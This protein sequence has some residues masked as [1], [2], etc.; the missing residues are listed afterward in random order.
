MALR[1][2]ACAA[3]P[4]VASF[5]LH[6]FPIET[7]SELKLEW[8]SVLKYTGTT[9]A[10]STDL[11][12]IGNTFSLD[13][14]FQ[15]HY[16]NFGAV[17]GGKAAYKAT[18][19]FK[20]SIDSNETGLRNA[21]AMGQFALGAVP[22][23]VTYGQSAL[24]WGEGVFFRSH[25]I[26]SAV[27]T[28]DA[29]NRGGLTSLKGLAEAG[30]ATVDFTKTKEF[31][32]PVEEATVEFYLP[33]SLRLAGY[34]QFEWEPTQVDEPLSGNNDLTV[35]GIVFDHQGDVEPPD[36]GQWGLKL[37]WSVQGTQGKS[38]Q[39]RGPGAQDGRPRQNQTAQGQERP[40]GIALYF[41]HY[42]P[43]NSN[44][45]FNFTGPAG[46]Y[47]NVYTQDAR[48]YGLSFNTKTYEILSVPTN[49]KGECSYRQGVP[50]AGSINITP[51]PVSTGQPL[52]A[53]GDAVYV[54]GSVYSKIPSIPAW[55]E[56]TFLAEIAWHQR[57]NVSLNPG[58]LDPDTHRDAAAIR[59]LFS[60]AYKDVFPHA[61]LTLQTGANMTLRGES[62]VLVSRDFTSEAGA[63]SWNIGPILNFF[64]QFS[65]GLLYTHYFAND[66]VQQ[67][68]WIWS[69]R[70]EF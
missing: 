27:T 10:E 56:A 32:L 39:G 34:Y 63:G 13:S 61:D 58:S 26:Y 23:T 28:I 49:F 8:D 6:A 12:T 68:S 21:Y 44:F 51:L 30:E 70:T 17:A 7:D 35:G 38:E 54:Q 48:L 66:D 57:V 25:G 50:L 4:S 9:S 40:A 67:D 43:R 62:D 20:N 52:H 15:A 3:G 1:L 41:L 22:A 46:V 5:P 2:L 64:E 19:Y 45:Y 60:P 69:F 42:H 11:G 29:K 65:T 37:T 36:S 16:R 14:E 33:W 47:S 53:L 59:F 55:D 24:E 18:S 31:A